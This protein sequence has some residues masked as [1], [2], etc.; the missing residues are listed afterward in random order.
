MS[1]WS[2]CTGTIEEVAPILGPGL[3]LQPRVMPVSAGLGRWRSSEVSGLLRSGTLLVH[4]EG[5][6]PCR[7]G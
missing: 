7:A 2:G 5:R 1:A 4:G 3:T 6:A